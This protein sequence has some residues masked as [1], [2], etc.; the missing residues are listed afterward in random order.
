[1]KRVRRPSRHRNRQP[2]PRNQGRGGKGKQRQT[3]SNSRNRRRCQQWRRSRHAGLWAFR[4]HDVAGGGAVV[5]VSNTSAAAM[6]SRVSIPARTRGGAVVAGGG[7]AVGVSNTSAAWRGRGRGSPAGTRGGAEVAGGGVVVVS[8]NT[9]A[10]A[11]QSRAVVV[12]AAAVKTSAA[13]LVKHPGGVGRATPAASGLRQHIAAVKHRG[14]SPST[15]TSRAGGFV[16]SASAKKNTSNTQKSP[17]RRQK[18]PAG[19]HSNT[20]KQG[21]VCP[22]ALHFWWV[23]ASPNHFFHFPNTIS[24]KNRRFPRAGGAKNKTQFFP[25]GRVC[26]RWRGDH[27]GAV[28]WSSVARE[29]EN[30]RS[31]AQIGRVLER[32]AP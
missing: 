13:G 28:G 6:R 14:G 21:R 25:A 9:S 31:L 27:R 5:G 16:R 30:G 11:R 26:A 2:S 17:W 29:R 8:G 12:V 15:S 19:N 20:Q 3:R 22:P 4:R 7:F 24:V 23:C 32:R 1:M 18:T 10:A